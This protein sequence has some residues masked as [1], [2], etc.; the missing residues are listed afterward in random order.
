MGCGPVALYNLLL[1]LGHPCSLEEVIDA[2]YKTNDYFLLDCIGLKYVYGISRRGFGKAMD[3]MGISYIGTHDLDEVRALDGPISFVVLYRNNNGLFSEHFIAI[4]YD[5]KTY[6]VYNRWSQ[7]NTF[8]EFNSI[9]EA[10]GGEERFHYAYI[11]H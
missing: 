10:I 1:S 2:F 7:S 9:E 4:D 3:E 5:G 8:T 11:P 6:R